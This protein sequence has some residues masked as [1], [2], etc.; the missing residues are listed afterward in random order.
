MGFRVGESYEEFVILL[1]E[2]REE[3]SMF[4]FRSLRRDRWKYSVDFYL[5]F[6]DGEE[7]CYFVGERC[8]GESK[9]G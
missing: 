9:M 4:L 7:D 1:S 2:M 5:E 3:M 6:L 8:L